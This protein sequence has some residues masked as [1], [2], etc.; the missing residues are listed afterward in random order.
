[1]PS[2][3][4]TDHAAR[5][6]RGVG[7]AAL[8]TAL[9]ACSSFDAGLLDA[10]Q[11]A[12]PVHEPQP[13]DAGHAS[14]ASLPD[15]GTTPAQKPDVVPDA[16]MSVNHAPEAGHAAPP[17]GDVDGGDDDAGSSSVCRPT[18][19]ADFCA[20]LPVL[21]AAAVIDGVL[22]CGPAE[23]AL[24]P[25]GWSGA[26]AMPAGLVT[27]LAAASRPDGIYVYVEVHGQVPVPH[28]AGSEIYC[29]DA[30]ELYVDASGTLDSA[31]HY[32]KPGT[33]QFI[34]AAPAVGGTTLE[35][36]RYVEGTA[37]GAWTGQV[38][39]VLLE[40]GYSVEA[41]VR[42]ADL[43]L[44]A[45]APASK[46]GLDVAIDVSAAAGTANL[47]CGQ[48]LGQYFLRLSTQADSCMGQPWCDTR[49]FCTPAL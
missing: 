20:R 15:T 45:W 36:M 39:T 3:C 22:D 5:C 12:P 32:S 41:F 48:E 23:L 38:K 49:A 28:P 24:D 10:T 8:L 26:S 17:P 18:A 13:R 11:P 21:P 44:A 35:A 34:V 29:G 2:R 31:G 42:A 9:G 47:R 40:D 25:K 27:R 1:M 7:C 14:D 4:R 6:W 37:N 43:D 16:A 46:I 33:M 19:V 30:V